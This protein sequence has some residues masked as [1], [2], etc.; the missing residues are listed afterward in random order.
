MLYS[1]FSLICVGKYYLVDCR[2]PLTRAYLVPYKAKRYH[3]AQF[4]KCE[5]LGYHQVFN[6]TRLSLGSIIEISFIIEDKV[7]DFEIYAKLKI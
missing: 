7:E 2:F 6:C 1:H 3:L 4:E 5:P